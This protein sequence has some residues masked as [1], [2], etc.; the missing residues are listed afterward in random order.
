MQNDSMQRGRYLQRSLHREE[1]RINGDTKIGSRVAKV[2]PGELPGYNPFRDR[3]PLSQLP[4]RP[5][6]DEQDKESE[7]FL[8]GVHS[9]LYNG[10]EYLNGFELVRSLRR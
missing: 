8:D 6:F 3:I 7:S 5:L 10:V 2:N 1:A 4:T 9:V